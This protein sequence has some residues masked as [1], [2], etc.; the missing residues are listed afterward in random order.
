M[1]EVGEPERG[2]ATRLGSPWFALFGGSRCWSKPNAGNR[3]T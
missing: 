1:G 2:F 3:Q